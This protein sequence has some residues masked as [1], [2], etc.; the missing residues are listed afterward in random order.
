MDRRLFL[1]DSLAASTLATAAA[2]GLLR[3]VKALAGAFDT[4][5]Q[6][7]TAESALAALLEGQPSSASDKIAVKAPEIAE[8]GAKV[9][10]QVE[11]SLEQ[12]Q[13]ISIIVPKNPMPLIAVYEPGSEF[14]GMVNTRI[15]MRE[16]SEVIALVRTP[17]GAFT[18]QVDVKVTLGGC[19][20]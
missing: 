6:A 12:V 19:G 16:T 9:P 7:E 13:S 20:G 14:A 4:A 3:P 8:N 5:F 1:R 10:V 11:T 2:A 15:K 17:E 18:A